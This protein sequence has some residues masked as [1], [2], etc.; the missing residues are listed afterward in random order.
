MYQINRIFHRKSEENEHNN[1]W[2]FDF[3]SLIYR[4]Q[5]KN[6]RQ[7]EI[8]R[9]KLNEIEIRGNCKYRMKI[10]ETFET[11]QGIFGVFQWK[12]ASGQKFHV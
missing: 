1:V 4:K 5:K 12:Q 6:K 8:E 10:K 7:S 11:D 9:K 2:H 3:Q